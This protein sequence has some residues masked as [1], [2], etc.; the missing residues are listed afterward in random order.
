MADQ[1]EDNTRNLNRITVGRFIGML[2]STVICLLFATSVS[3][4]SD[5]SKY[6]L[7]N[8]VLSIVKYA[9]EIESI[10]TL[11]IVFLYIRR[12]EKFHRDQT[13]FWP[14]RCRHCA[15]VLN[16]VRSLHY[17]ESD[18]QGGIASNNEETSPLV[19]PTNTSHLV[20]G[21]GLNSTTTT[22]TTINDI[23]MR[24]MD[25][26]T[27]DFYLLEPGNSTSQSVLP[28]PGN[29]SSR[30]SCTE[31]TFHVQN[32]VLMKVF[33]VFCSICSLGV[34]T[35][36]I[37]YFLCYAEGNGPSTMTLISRTISAIIMSLAIPL[38]IV[39]GEG[40][41]D[42]I[43]LDSYTNLCAIALMLFW[44]IW[45]SAIRL[46]GPINKLLKSY[47]NYNISN[48]DL[49]VNHTDCF[50]DTEL[51]GHIDH[52]MKPFYTETSLIL[53]A[54]ALQWWNSFVPRTS[55]T[56]NTNSL[57]SETH[58]VDL[59]FPW[60]K[61]FSFN[62]KRSVRRI[63]Q[64]CHLSETEP[65]LSIN[66][67]LRF[68]SCFNLT[69]F[70]VLI[71]NLP[72]MC[73]SFYFA[74]GPNHSETDSFYEYAALWSFETAFAVSMCVLFT[75][76]N[77]KQKKR[78][79]RSIRGS[80]DSVIWKLKGHEMMLL[81]SSHGIFCQRIFLMI[82]AADI[83]LTNHALD[84][85]TH[86]LCTIAIVLSTVKVVMV[87]Q[88]A[89]LLISI[90]RQKLDN[91]CDVLDKKRISVCL[92]SVIVMSGT[93]WLI[94]SIDNKSFPL[95]RLYFGDKPGQAIGVLLEPFE[96]IFELHAAM[97]A[98]ELYKEM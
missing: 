41:T 42:A 25:I 36:I 75:Y 34:I 94:T 91:S 33:S 89:G 35:E 16:P 72:Y 12:K 10:I 65:L 47:R 97:T 59:S 29:D 87:W 88:M 37:K 1:E 20:E 76:R 67:S 4:V 11:F 28:F 3:L 70:I 73:L 46:H 84:G 69:W 63:Q 13:V 90:P 23:S 80:S 19:S 44:C 52:M 78:G 39:F 77:I 22:T 18:I 50:K 85:E 95:E 7:M 45:E 55:I 26:S 48:A 51:F 81:V 60:K 62:I 86:I 49:M 54:I 5:G 53:L 21:E 15:H 96:T 6:Q 31:N 24:H 14:T 74:F 2:A 27:N 71:A 30:N 83:L 17:V 9:I 79:N 92:I 38:L 8:L 66:S 56:L 93:Q 40:F 82:A 98:L 61:I 58:T 57:E 32:R 68:A 43:F 64:L